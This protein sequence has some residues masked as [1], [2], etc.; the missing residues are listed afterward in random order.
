MEG[1]VRRLVG[2]LHLPRAVSEKAEELF[3]L[4][5][6]RGGVGGGRGLSSA[7]LSLA[8]VEL[9]CCELEEPL[10]KVPIPSPPVLLCS[11]LP[12]AGL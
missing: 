9:A 12:S 10:D 3:R 11:S 8:C 6:V 1:A 2:H 7:S 5:E 4:L